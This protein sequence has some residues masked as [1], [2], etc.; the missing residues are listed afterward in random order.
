MIDQSSTT[1]TVSNILEPKISQTVPYFV[2]GASKS[3]TNNGGN[4]VYANINS[5]SAN[6]QKIIPS[7]KANTL[8]NHLKTS[9]KKY[10]SSLY[11]PISALLTQVSLDLTP[12]K[13]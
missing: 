4:G 10:R 11:A 3:L 8:V 9:P 12:V 2:S 5:S 7:N 13:N 6:A 1:M